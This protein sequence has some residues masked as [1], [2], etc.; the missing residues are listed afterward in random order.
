MTA[1]IEVEIVYALPNIQVLKKMTVPDNCTVGEAL[2]LSGFLE[3]FPEIDPA[4][5][6]LGIFGK[7]VGP[8]TSLQSRDRIEIYRPL[9]IDPK[10]IRRIRAKRSLGS[11]NRKS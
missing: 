2:A 4:K 6:K 11:E 7:L 1:V 8:H 3:Q 10:E 9:V 5:N